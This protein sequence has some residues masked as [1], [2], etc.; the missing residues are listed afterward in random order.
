MHSNKGTLL[1][2][3]MPHSPLFP[4]T[5]PTLSSDL[6][7]QDP[8][9][10]TIER[11]IFPDC[12]CHEALL[13]T[14]YRIRP[15]GDFPINGGTRLCFGFDVVPCSDPTSK[16]CN[17]VRG[18][19]ERRDGRERGSGQR[20]RR[21]GWGGRG[22]RRERKEGREGRKRARKEDGRGTICQERRP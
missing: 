7:G 17:M 15:I 16:C 21:G 10:A 4:H 20:E 18:C 9:Q 3:Y 12:E 14:P 6:T 22:G 5:C 2:S 11:S 8:V 1:P 19:G 13:G